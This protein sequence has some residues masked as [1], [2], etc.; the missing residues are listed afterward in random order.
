MQKRDSSVLRCHQYALLIKS[1]NG[2]VVYFMHWHIQYAFSAERTFRV[3]SS[4][5]FQSNQSLTAWN[6]NFMATM[7]EL[8]KRA[9]RHGIST[10]EAVKVKHGDD[11]SSSVARMTLTENCLA[12]WTTLWDIEHLTILFRSS[13]HNFL[14]IQSASNINQSDLYHSPTPSHKLS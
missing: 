4:P 13:S 1:Q 14:S 12:I 6:A 10:D 5:H 8:H 11:R 2:L 3:P 7:D 9:H